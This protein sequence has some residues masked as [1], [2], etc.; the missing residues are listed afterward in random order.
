VKWSFRKLRLEV[1]G[2]WTDKTYTGA[3][4]V[5]ATTT[6]AKAGEE[7]FFK[8]RLI[9]FTSVSYRLTSNLSLF[10]AGDRAYDS[11]K[12]WYY[13]SDHRIR[14]VETTAASGASA[15]R[16]TSKAV[17]AH[18]V[19]SR[20]RVT[21]PFSFVSFNCRAE[22]ATRPALW[23]CS[24][25]SGLRFQVSGFRGRRPRRLRPV[26]LRRE[27]LRAGSRTPFTAAHSS[28]RPE[29]AGAPPRKPET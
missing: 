23:F 20:A 15:S 16:A 6:V 26:V 12:I 2:T 5:A 24:A 28:A 29:A 22:S 21:G 17:S 9:L 7:E 27:E 1:N 14:Q 10:V 3:N 8:P 13:Q 19:Q 25:P 18:S 4:T 11:G